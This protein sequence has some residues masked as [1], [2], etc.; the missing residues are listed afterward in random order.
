MV[1][2]EFISNMGDDLN[3]IIIFIDY[4]FE[5]GKFFVEESVTYAIKNVVIQFLWR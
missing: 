2:L 4:K 3:R 1:A 5:R